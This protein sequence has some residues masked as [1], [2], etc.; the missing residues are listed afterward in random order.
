MKHGDIGGSGGKG[1]S[2]TARPHPP[3]KAQTIRTRNSL[4]AS[5]GG[6]LRPGPL[7]GGARAPARR[8][9]AGP[10]ERGSCVPTQPPQASAA[11][12]FPELKLTGSP[13]PGGSSNGSPHPQPAPQWPPVQPSCSLGVSTPRAGP[14]PPHSASHSELPSLPGTGTCCF[15]CPEPSPITRHP[16]FRASLEATSP[17]KPPSTT[18]LCP[19]FVALGVTIL[20]TQPLPHCRAAPHPHAQHPKRHVP[21]QGIKRGAQEQGQLLPGSRG[22]ERRL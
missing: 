17:W 5:P 6:K 19:G 14:V 2:H 7:T 20:F 4:E 1:S 10:G 22:P 8:S 21:N 13:P 3:K 12:P 11:S 18:D 15:L 16:P 9:P